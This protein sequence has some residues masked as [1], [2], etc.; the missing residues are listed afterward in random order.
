MAADKLEKRCIFE[1]EKKGKSVVLLSVVHSD[2]NVCDED[3]NK[4]DMVSF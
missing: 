1:L 2:E 3:E 4:H